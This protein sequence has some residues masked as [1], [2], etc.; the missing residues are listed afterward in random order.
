MVGREGRVVNRAAM[1]LGL[2]LHVPFCASICNYCNFNRGLLDA[3]LKE[4]Y[5]RALEQDQERAR[6]REPADVT[7]SAHDDAD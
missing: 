5:V 3:G 1:S 2:Y 7:D 4:R 6:T